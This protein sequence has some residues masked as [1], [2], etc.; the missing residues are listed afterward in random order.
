MILTAVAAVQEGAVPAVFPLAV[1]DLGNADPLPV[2]AA[3]AGHFVQIQ[4]LPPGWENKGG[5][6]LT[7]GTK[8]DMLAL[9]NSVAP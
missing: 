4:S 2:I 3:E 7:N 1:A 9:P 5:K 6:A 8:C